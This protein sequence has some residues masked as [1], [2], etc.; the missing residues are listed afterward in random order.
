MNNV[1]KQNFASLPMMIEKEQP[2]S[3]NPTF[4][5]HNNESFQKKQDDTINNPTKCTYDKFYE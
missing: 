5:I 4:I 3:K 2:Q 1:E